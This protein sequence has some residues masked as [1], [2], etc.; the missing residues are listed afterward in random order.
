MEEEEEEEIPEKIIFPPEKQIPLDIFQVENIDGIIDCHLAA[1]FTIY[2]IRKM[3]LPIPSDCTVKDLLFMIEGIYL[4]ED[5]TKDQFLEFFAQ[6][7]KEIKDEFLNEDDEFDEEEEYF[8]LTPKFIQ[9]HLSDLQPVE[10]SD[11]CFTFSAFCLRNADV[12]DVKPIA[13]FESLTTISLKS[14]FIRDISPL[15]KMPRLK[16]L[17]LTGNIIRKIKQFNFPVLEDLNLSKNIIN[18]VES[19]NCPKLKVLNV[20]ENK[21]FYIAPYMLEKCPSLEVLDFSTNLIR[22]IREG[23]FV[24]LKKLKELKLNI[25]MLTS[26]AYSISKDLREVTSIDLSDNPLNNLNGLDY[27]ISLKTCDLHKTALSTLKELQPLFGH[28][29]LKVLNIYETALYDVD[30]I[31]LDIIHLCPTIEVIDE[32]PVTFNER[33]DSEALIAYRKE[34]E[35]EEEENELLQTEIYTEEED[36]DNVNYEFKARLN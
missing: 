33:L 23:T 12:T 30:D 7:Y 11:F 34:E 29:C 18:T 2:A 16:N 27:L 25:N 21:I 10:G 28:P 8:E 26:L 3:D 24:G 15:Q 31:R 35:E 36:T 1:Y 19:I 14:N 32:E 20:S 9:D 6:C 17:D 13:E 4:E 22:D 5:F